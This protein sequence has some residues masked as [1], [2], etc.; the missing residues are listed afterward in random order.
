MVKIIDQFLKKT[1]VTFAQ[2]DAFA[3]G[4]G[5]G[6]FTSLRVGLST[7]K[8]FCLATGKKAVG[9]PSMD[10]IAM[11]VAHIPCD[12]ICV[13]IDA[14][15]EKCYTAFYTPTKN[16][17]KR[18]SEYQLETLPEIIKQVQG[19]TLFVGDAVKK[20]QSQ[21]QS[22]RAVFAPEQLAQ[23]QATCLAEAA[24]ERLARGDYDNIHHMQPLYLYGADCQVTRA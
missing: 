2:L 22:P 16:G 24:F 11:G 10:V 9:I 21:L 1:K 3:V 12:Q 6:S 14:R 15:R 5:P 23:P 19:K 7:V 18:N 17:L 20:Y 8:A 13:L 4:L